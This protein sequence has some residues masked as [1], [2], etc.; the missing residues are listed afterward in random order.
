MENNGPIPPLEENIRTN[1]GLEMKSEYSAEATPNHESQTL[2]RKLSLKKGDQPLARTEDS[3][4][5]AIHP[6]APDVNLSEKIHGAP[7]D[8]GLPSEDGLSPEQRFLGP[9]FSLVHEIAFVFTM[10]LSNILTQ[11]G[12][13]QTVV[14]LN[15]IGQGLDVQDS[16]QLSWFVA[17]YSL[18]V[19]TFILIAGRLGDIFG[20]KTIFITGFFWFGIWSMITG[21]SVYTHSPIF[22]NVCRALQ[23]IGP[24]MLVPN[25][26]A[27]LGRTYPSGRRKEMIFSIYGATA[28]NVTRPRIVENLVLT[29]RTGFYT[30]S[31]LRR[32]SC[33][34]CMVAMDLLV[35]G[36]CLLSLWHAFHLRNTLIAQRQRAKHFFR[37]PWF[38]N[39]G[40]RPGSLQ[41][42][43]ER[44][45]G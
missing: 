9:P 10:C 19:G 30:R 5:P 24:A 8:S 29:E 22:F 21:V 20:H 28:P 3:S 40:W 6:N 1:N 44:G 36:N 41:C 32:A 4:D 13:S 18:T 25:S 37:L 34:A 27:L 26:L 23:G 12:L 31:C 17:A 11:A 42:G 14:P 38:I 16:G 39:R 35:Y 15:I 33:A 45:T 43:V 7:S 2:P